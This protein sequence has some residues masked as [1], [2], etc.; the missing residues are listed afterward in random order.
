MIEFIKQFPWLIVAGAL[1]QII[2][3]VGAVIIGV[4]NAVHIRHVDQ[5]INQAKRRGTRVLCP[6]CKKESDLADVH[7]L[8]PDGSIDD[9]LNGKPDKFEV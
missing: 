4:V 2:A 8:L 3:A 5:H 9:N 6:H 7:F 1:C